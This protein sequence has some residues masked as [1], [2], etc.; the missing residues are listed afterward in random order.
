[1]PHRPLEIGDRVRPDPESFRAQTPPWRGGEIGTVEKAEMRPYVMG[2]QRVN[3]RM[4]NQTMLEG[5][6]G[7]SLVVVEE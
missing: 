3:V 4:P 6:D 1:M 2:L 5:L 7:G